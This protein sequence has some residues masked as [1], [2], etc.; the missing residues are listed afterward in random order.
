MILRN[1]FFT[2]VLA[3][4]AVL[5]AGPPFITDATFHGSSLS[6]WHTLGQA[7][8]TAS[9]G[10]I[11]GRPKSAGGGWLLMDQGL[12]DLGV[13]VSFRCPAGCKSGIVMRAQKTGDGMKGLLVSLTEGDVGLYRITLDAEGRETQRE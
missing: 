11:T 10:E 9:N 7:E 13:Y 5:A 6:G 4:P 1:L 3:A 12:Q 2:A 8:W